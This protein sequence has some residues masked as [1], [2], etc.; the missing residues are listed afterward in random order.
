[1]RKI[2]DRIV[3]PLGLRVVR[4]KDLEIVYLHDYKGGYDEYRKV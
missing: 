1:M 4:R 2:L 3:R